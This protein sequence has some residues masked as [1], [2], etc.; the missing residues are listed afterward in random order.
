MTIFY[1]QSLS[2]NNL[3]LAEIEQDKQKFTDENTAIKKEIQK[4]LKEKS[5]QKVSFEEYRNLL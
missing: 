5:D 1:S 4:L 3:Q 2:E